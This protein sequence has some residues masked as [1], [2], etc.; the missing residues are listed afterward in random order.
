MIN[1]GNV[2]VGDTITRNYQIGNTNTGGPSLSGA[3]QTA[4]NGGHLTDSQ[5]PATA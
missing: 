1:F 5:F 4:V 3:I 2:H